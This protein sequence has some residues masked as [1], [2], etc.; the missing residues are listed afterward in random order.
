MHKRV[1]ETSVE[2][3]SCKQ[4]RNVRFCGTSTQYGL[5]ITFNHL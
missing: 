4:L 1:T 3:A 5:D 2:L